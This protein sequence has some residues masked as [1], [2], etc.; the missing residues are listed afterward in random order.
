MATVKLTRVRVEALLKINPNTLPPRSTWQRPAL[1]S[2]ASWIRAL[3][4]AGLRSAEESRSLPARPDR[5][6]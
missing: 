5:S 2:L 6:G 1:R 4:S 3:V